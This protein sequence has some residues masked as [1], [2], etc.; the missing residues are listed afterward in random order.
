MAKRYVSTY[1][2]EHNIKR[3]FKDY[4]ITSH[5]SYS[6]SLYMSIHINNR[7]AK[8]RISNHIPHKSKLERYNVVLH[9]KYVFYVTRSR[10]RYYGYGRLKDLKRDIIH[11][12]KGENK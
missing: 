10:Y 12:Y 7:K 11:T 2:V 6:G 9:S 1:K 5:R 8:I 3:L 4:K